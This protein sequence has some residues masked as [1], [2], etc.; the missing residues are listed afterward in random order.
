MPLKIA[1]LAGD[2][3]GA[4]VTAA[5]LSILESCIAIEVSEGLIGGAAIDAT[6]DPLPPATVKLCSGSDAVL[7][8]AVGGP[9]WEGTVRAETGLLRLRREL[10]VYANLRPARYMSLP[11]PLREDLARKADILVVRELLGGVYFGEPRGTTE[12]AAFNTW[13]QSREEIERVT[14]LAFKK[15]RGRRAR[16]TS[17]DKANVL[18]ASRLWRSVVSEIAQQYPDVE[19]EHRFVDSAAFDILN[20]PHQFDVVL[21]ENLFGD[22]LSDM[23][24]ALAGSL[25]V[26]PSASI[27]LSTPLFEPVHGSAPDIAG[28]GTANPAGAIL[29]VAMLLEHFGEVDLARAL[30]AAVA[31][32]FKQLRTPDLGGTATTAEFTDAV[33][34]HLSWLRFATHAEAD[35][36]AVA[37]WGV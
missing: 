36:S 35:P 20:T 8:G 17:V 7:L 28:R 22:I 10:G 11:T 24:G 3:I 34:G 5:A 23:A 21:T 25:G 16:V 4:E 1:V 30:E 18:E 12:D 31:E 9:R 19:L 29:T 6:G 2:G 14:H 27:G 32:T 15:A 26:L 37:P 33:R 13:R